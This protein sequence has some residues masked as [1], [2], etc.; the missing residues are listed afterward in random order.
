[1]AI[2]LLGANNP[3]TVRVIAAIKRERSLDVVGFIDNDPDKKNTDFYGYPVLGGFE[4]L[5]SLVGEHEFVNIITR[6]C[7]T[8]FET[9]RCIADAGGRFANLIHPNVNLEMTTVGLGNYFQECAILQAGV[10]VGNNSSISFGSLIG[11]ESKVGNSVFFAPGCT[12][13]GKVCI[14]D[15]VFVGAGATVLPRLTIGRWSV[16]GAGSVV[17]A[18]VPPYSVVVGNPA[19]ILRQIEPLYADGDVV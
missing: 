4:M 3:E 7:V 10:A 5:P 6:D 9:S 1:M 15:G 19:R 8:R 13:A 14:E 16:V 18:D 11:H 2:V 17:T 12:V